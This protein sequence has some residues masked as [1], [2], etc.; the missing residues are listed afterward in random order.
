MLLQ[1]LNFVSQYVCLGSALWLFCLPVAYQI[2][3][4]LILS[5]CLDDVFLNG[6]SYNRRPADGF[7]LLVA[8]TLIFLAAL[9]CIVPPFAR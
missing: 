9:E 5:F 2:S 6:N 1:Q 4:C 3:F 7:A 8:W